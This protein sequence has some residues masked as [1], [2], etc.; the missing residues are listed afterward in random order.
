MRIGIFGGTFNPIHKGH[1]TIARHALAACRMDEVWFVVSPRNPFKQNDHLA[2]DHLRLEM[3]RRA[4]DGEEKMVCSDYEFRLPQPSYTWHT[5]RGLTTDY[6]YDE[7]IL[8][9]GADNWKRFDE[10]SHGQDILSRHQ[11]VVYPR[12]GCVIERES[13]PQGVRYLDFPL[14]NVSATDIRHAIARGEDVEEVVPS[15]AL[16]VIEKNKLYKTTER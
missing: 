8:L 13:L 6:P 10:W 2:E 12:S 5:L 3:V 16:D 1:I 15:G 11:V 7:F 14:I 9:I 4:I